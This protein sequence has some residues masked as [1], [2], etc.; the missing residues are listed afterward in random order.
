MENTAHGSFAFKIMPDY[1]LVTSTGA[2]NLECVRIHNRILETRAKEL[3]GQRRAAIVD[4]RFWEFETPECAEE[5]RRF[6]QLMSDHRI[7]FHI[8][9]W[10]SEKN[11]SLA[12]HIIGQRYR[13]FGQTVSWQ[14]CDTL[15]ESV[16]WI[17]SEGF[18]IPDIK[19]S[20]FP[21]PI[22]ASDYLKQ[23]G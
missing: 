9:Y 17:R 1:T 15:E 14:V 4:G 12:R 16:S 23:M 6:Y 10:S 3:A 11:A 2:W 18:D 19:A 20:D 5:Y 21:A 8:A 22:P 7:R 13:D